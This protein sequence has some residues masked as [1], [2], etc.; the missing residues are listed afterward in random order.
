MSL[1]LSLATALVRINRARPMSEERHPAPVTKRLLDLCTVSTVQVD[2]R[3]VVT[4]VPRKGATGTEL[5]YLHGGSYIHPISVFHWDIL[6]NIIERTGA[7]VTVPMYKL[8]PA[9]GPA[10]AY[11]LLDK[12]Y[13]SVVERAG[14][15]PVFLGG[16]SA[17]GGLALGQAIRIRDAGGLQPAGLILFSP[18]VELTMS[19]PAIPD[20]ER[21]EAMLSLSASKAAAKLWA[22]DLADPVASPV[23]D[24]LAGLPPLSIYQG[25]NEIL[26]PDV[27][28]LV[29]KARAAGTKVHYWLA[30]RAFHVWVALGWT[31]E[32]KS[33]LDDVAEQMKLND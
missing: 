12:V 25:G 28:T 22:D 5:I 33:A 10:D 23:N 29:N 26:L 1:R 13:A 19:N 6:Q 17:G 4:V 14:E 9:G 15:N 18:W 21:R 3:D 30:P 20:F 7:T 2:E 27:E 24:S 32:A 16:D 8:G 11:P 31:P